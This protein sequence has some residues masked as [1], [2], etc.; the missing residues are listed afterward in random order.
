MRG[1]MVICIDQYFNNQFTEGS[2][3]ILRLGWGTGFRN[4]TGDWQEDMM[5]DKDLDALIKELRPKHDINL[6]YPKTRRM[7]SDGTPLG[8]IQLT[9]QN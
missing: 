3:C 6:T 5:T 4:M 7:A 8:F 2:S 9:Q 1:S